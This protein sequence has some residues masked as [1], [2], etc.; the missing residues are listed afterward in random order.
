M[1]ILI[2]LVPNIANIV[3][4]MLTMLSNISKYSQTMF[5]YITCIYH[6]TFLVLISS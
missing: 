6:V 1:S 5:D 4:P 2:Y 3:N